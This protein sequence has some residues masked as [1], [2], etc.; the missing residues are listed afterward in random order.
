M[1]SNGIDIDEKTQEWDNKGPA[2]MDAQQQAKDAAA[3]AKERE[4]VLF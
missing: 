2:F 3:K 1:K 4:G